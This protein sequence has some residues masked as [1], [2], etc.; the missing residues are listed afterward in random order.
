MLVG[1]RGPDH[2]PLSPLFSSSALFLHLCRFPSSLL[3][4][5]PLPLSF[6]LFSPSPSSI[7]RFPSSLLI[8]A[9][10]H[11]SS[12]LV[13]SLLSPPIVLALSRL[14]PHTMAKPVALFHLVPANDTARQALSHPDNRRFVSPARNDSLGLEIGFHVASVP[15][16]VM[17]R[18]G[19]D[20]DLILQQRNVSGVHVSFEMHPETLVVML[21]SRTKRTSSVMVTPTN[22]SGELIYGDCVLS[23]GTKY[24]I[25]IADY[26]F[27]LQWRGGTALSLRE[28][29]IREY[30]EAL[31]RQAQGNVHSRYLP[32]EADSETHTW[33]NTRIHS[34][35]RALFR[36]AEG[37]RRQ[38]IGGGQFGE[39]YRAVD[40]LTGNSFAI[41][42]LL[43][44]K[45]RNPED[46]RSHAHRE[47]KVLERLEHENIVE[48]LGHAKWGTMRPEIFMPLR[49]GSLKDLVTTRD[50]AELSDNKLSLMVLGQMLSALDYLAY[51]NVCHRDVKPDNII[52]FWVRADSKDPPDDKAYTFQLADFGLTTFNRL[53]LTRCGSPYYM[54]PEVYYGKGA[55][56]PKVDVW[57]LFATIADIH[58]CFSFPPA[59]ANE[60]E[61]VLRAIRIASLVKHQLTPM[62]RED[63]N[64]RASAAQMLVSAFG[65]RGLTTPLSKV[66]P[67]PDAQPP[68]LS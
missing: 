28:L 59:A 63:P 22:G 68:C 11:L 41:K 10:F 15:G 4:V 33:H 53:A 3:I 66:P 5:S 16:R 36:E 54:A 24:T 42:V 61:D 55:Q 46:A 35:R 51:N 43:L 21:S 37:A 60:Y 9:L 30:N 64:H 31:K 50:V 34:A 52:Y 25:A 13:S 26:K 67:I 45:C 39:V 49:M 14:M 7:C 19:R 62:V 65:G 2:I 44:D 38:L 12:S 27:S 20:A 56:T 29:S 6:P 1:A 23:Y 17:A 58:A 47:I 57:S 40:D 18:L 48:F 32:T 8:V